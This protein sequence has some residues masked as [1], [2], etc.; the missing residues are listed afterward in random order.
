MV[1]WTTKKG[2]EMAAEIKHELLSGN[3][4]DIFE[5]DFDVENIEWND[6]KASNPEW[7]ASFTNKQFRENVSRMIAKMIKEQDAADGEAADIGL[8]PRRHGNGKA[9]FADS[10]H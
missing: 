3:W 8:G 7:D 1:K 10:P 6:L 9:F 4:G 5:P 2:K